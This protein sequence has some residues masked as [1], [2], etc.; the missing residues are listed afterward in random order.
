M[1]IIGQAIILTYFVIGMVSNAIVPFF[2][3]AND[4]I[5]KDL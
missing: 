4:E 3:D 2:L 5:N 1:D